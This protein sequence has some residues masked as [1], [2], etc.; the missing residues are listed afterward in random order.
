MASIQFRRSIYSLPKT[1]SGPLSSPP[2]LSERHV[3]AN[4]ATSEDSQPDLGYQ[5][6]ISASW[7]QKMQRFV[8]WGLEK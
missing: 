7:R 2:F 4:R 1:H 5:G 6:A 8:Y 3:S